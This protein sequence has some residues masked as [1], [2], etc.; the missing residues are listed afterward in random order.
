MWEGGIIL[1]QD[2]ENHFNHKKVILASLNSFSGV[3]IGTP[4]I[5]P[6]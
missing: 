1:G 3:N 2:L 5:V 6:V 4:I